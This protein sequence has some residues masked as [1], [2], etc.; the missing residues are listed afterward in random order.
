MFYNNLWEGYI[1]K[2]IVSIF[3]RFHALYFQECCYDQ[4]IASMPLI[5]RKSKE[6]GTFLKY[7]PFMYKSLHQDSDKNP[8]VW[9]CELSDLCDAYHQVRPV[10]KCAGYV[11][12]T[13]GKLIIVI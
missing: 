1:L 11:P 7:N 9:C 2:E 6:A 12:P 8:K 13:L 5:T 10:D 3:K 4:T